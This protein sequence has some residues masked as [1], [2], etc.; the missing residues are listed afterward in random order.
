[1]ARHSEQV[2]A[3]RFSKVLEHIDRSLDLPLDVAHLSQLA[4]FSPYHFHRQF[5]A[6]CG[7]SVGR[8]FQLMR[9]K[10]ASLCLAFNKHE[11]IIDI[12]LDAGFKNPESFSRAF[13]LA[14]AQTP[15]DFRRHPDWAGWSRR[16]PHPERERK[17]SMDVRIVN[18]ASERV[19]VL[20]HRGSPDMLNASAQRFVEWRKSSHLAPLSRGRTYGIA[21]DN[22][23]TTTPEAFRFDLCCTV[24]QAVPE[25]PQGVM[26]GEMPAGRCAV[27]RHHGSHDGL[28]E[29]IYSLYRDWLPGS[30]EQLRDYPLYFHYL[31]FKFDTPEHELLTDIYLPLQG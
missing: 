18:V 15:T 5:T 25:N 12:A 22:P 4:H 21:Y 7:V 29:S 13:R 30:G 23:A 16:L 10:R 14:F 11:R 27:L 20:Q 2:Y 8:Y 1:M 3:R 28:P 19:A 24:E 9:L 17:I 26:N 6:W 31:N